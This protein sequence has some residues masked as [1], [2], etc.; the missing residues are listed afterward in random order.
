M[1]T[2]RQVFEQ[3][4]S[5]RGSKTII[6]GIGNTLKGDDGVGPLVCEQL[7]QAGIAAEIID[8]GTVPENYIQ[9][10]TKKAPQNLLIIDAIDF[11]AGPGTIKIFEPHE[12]NAFIVSTHTLSPRLFA[13]L[14]SRNIKVDIYFIGIQPAQTQLG[15]SVSAE[16]AQAAEQ[17]SQ[18]L[19]DIFR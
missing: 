9:R 8:A 1:G 14:V 12:L 2:D 13:E 3:I 4:S 6:V 15:Q 18:S 5:L 11:G 16:A 19:A 7:R 10:I 17:L